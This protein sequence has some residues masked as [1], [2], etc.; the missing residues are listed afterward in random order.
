MAVAAGLLVAGMLSFMIG[1]AIP[2]AW[3][4]K[5]GVVPEVW[6][7]PLER[8]L[9]LIAQ[10]RGSWAWTNGFMI[11]AVVLNAAGT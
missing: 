5:P 7:A 3:L 4:E 1:A 10:H 8:Y 2:L 6:S 9:Q 11:T